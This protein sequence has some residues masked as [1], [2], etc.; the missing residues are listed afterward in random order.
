MTKSMKIVPE[1]EDKIQKLFE[2][3]DTNNSGTIDYSEFLVA[4]TDF[5][6]Q[7]AYQYFEEAFEHF[8]IDNN[9]F[10]TFREV[11]MF[12][13]IEE[14]QAQKIFNEVDTNRDGNI[15]KKEFVEILLP[16]T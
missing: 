10:I 4:V 3:L 11:E 7:N 6:Y 12:L 16:K 5:H 1:K 13:E 8:D 15:S 9:G 2:Y 14:E